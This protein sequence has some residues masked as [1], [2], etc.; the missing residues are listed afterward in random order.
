VPGAPG[1]GDVR[2][3]LLAAALGLFLLA[4]PARAATMSIG[5]LT[6]FNW[7]EISDNPSEDIYDKYEYNLEPSFLYGPMLSFQITPEWNVSSLFIM[8]SYR[9]EFN[10]VL[11]GYAYSSSYDIWRYDSD[12]TVSYAF[13]PYFR[14]FLGFKFM[15]YTYTIDDSSDSGDGMTYIYDDYAPGAGVIFTIAFTKNIYLSISVGAL[16]SFT[17][18]TVENIPDDVISVILLDSWYKVGA[19]ARMILNFTIEK[20]H[21]VITTGFRYQMFYSFSDEYEEFNSVQHLYG[22]E[23]SVIFYFDI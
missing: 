12:T 1:G 8:G 21:M 13:T 15:R 14:L 6:W 17:N 9:S 7:W 19:N 10:G 22:P 2:L 5:Y 11:D 3:R 16:F 18:M 4:Q 23:L 20:A